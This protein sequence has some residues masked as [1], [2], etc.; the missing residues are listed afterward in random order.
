MRMMTWIKKFYDTY[1]LTGRRNIPENYFLKED[2]YNDFLNATL[3]ICANATLVA[4]VPDSDVQRS[5][6]NGNF[7]I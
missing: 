3:A 6:M 4:H 7:F 1:V 2:G 5:P